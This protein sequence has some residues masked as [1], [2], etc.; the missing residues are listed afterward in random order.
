MRQQ[1]V[2]SGVLSGGRGAPGQLPPRAHDQGHALGETHSKGHAHPHVARDRGALLHPPRTQHPDRGC[3]P[4]GFPWRS[5]EKGE[6][7]GR[8]AGSKK[9]GRIGQGSGAV[10]AGAAVAVPAGLPVDGQRSTV[11]SVTAQ[12][13]GRWTRSS[14][15]AASLGWLRTRREP[16]S[17]IG[18]ASR[19]EWRN[20]VKWVR[21]AGNSSATAFDTGLRSDERTF[22]QRPNYGSEA[23]VKKPPVNPR[24]KGAARRLERPDVGAN[25]A[26]GLDPEADLWHLIAQKGLRC[27]SPGPMVLARRGPSPSRVTAPPSPKSARSGAA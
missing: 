14:P 17:R 21:V 9:V 11:E 24:K 19:R 26:S 22:P 23:P 15:S 18:A 1:T 12:T 27:P 2:S 4:T 20:P 5:L 8:S 16:A 6:G 7:S 13:T 25:G 10:Q 3:D